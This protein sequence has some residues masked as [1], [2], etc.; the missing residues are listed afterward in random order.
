L[1]LTWSE[2]KR[3]LAAMAKLLGI[4]HLVT[5]AVIA[6]VISSLVVAARLR[7]GPW[8][9][10]PCRILAIVI[11]ANEAAWW[12]WLA[13][14]GT[15]SASYA[16]PFQ[17]CDVAAVVSAAA[18]WF[19]Q[20]LLIEL[21]YF[22]GLAGTA[23]GLITPD[24]SDHFPSFG[25]MQYFIAHGAIVA[26]ALFLVIGLKLTPRPGAVVRVFGLTFGLLVLDASIN[27]L[28]GGNYMY[29]RHTPGAHSLLDML[30]PW[31]L[32]IVGAA[33][34]ALVLFAILDLPFALSRRRRKLERAMG[35]EPT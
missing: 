32:Y 11:V 10:F 16:L 31:P 29:L 25:F 9:V 4:E 12:V 8:T 35:I 24:I 19:R 28:T 7:P 26:A 15:W 1:G 17:L 22:W 18:L 5:L 23:N 30:G 33:T 34:L 2:L 20:P 3:K 13:G 6:A 14:H 21:T 27:L